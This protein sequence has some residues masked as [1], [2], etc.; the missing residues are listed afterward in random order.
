MAASETFPSGRT[1]VS[2]AEF[3]AHRGISEVTVRRYL[4]DGR[5]PYVQAVRG[6]RIMIPIDA[7]NERPIEREPQPA[8]P[9]SG[10]ASPRKRRGPMAK[11]MR[12]RPPG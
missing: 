12:H 2:P 8:P 6:G 9:T 1:H 5:L 4:R 10:A 7:L 11:W 3:A